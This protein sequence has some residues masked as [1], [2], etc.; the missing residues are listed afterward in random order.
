MEIYR[1]ILLGIAIVI[2]VMV[3]GALYWSIIDK[4]MPADE[5]EN[6]DDVRG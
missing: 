2:G 6:T 1:G 4:Y 5:H 3:I